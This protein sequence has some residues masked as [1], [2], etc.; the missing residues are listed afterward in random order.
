MEIGYSW[1]LLVLGSILDIKYK[2]LPSWFLVAG[3]VLAVIGAVVLKPVGLWE[4]AGGLLLG[5]L[6]FVVSLLTRGAL[7]K[8]DGIFIGIVGLNLGFSTIFSV[9]MGAL[10][11]A[12]FLA[13]LLLIVKKANRK[14]AFPFL[15]FLGVSY[16]IICI[17]SFL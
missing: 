5:V 11:L 3:G 12:A 13:V 9:F 6:L 7:G 4:M 15:P 2:A 8:G 14:T 10:L 1:I 16:G 17:S